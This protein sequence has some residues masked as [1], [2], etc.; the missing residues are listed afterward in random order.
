[1]P[2]VEPFHAPWFPAD[3]EIAAKLL[4][5]PGD[6][7]RGARVEP[8]ARRLLAAMRAP[9]GMGNVEK[10]LQEYSLS[11]REGLALMALAE[12]LLRVPDDSTLDLLIADKLAAGAFDRHAPASD[13]L[14]VQAAA[15]ALGLSTKIFATEETP[16]GLVAQA[17]RRLG[18]PALRGAARQAMKLMGGHFVLGQTIDEALARASADERWRYSFDMLGEGA[19]SVADAERY[20]AAYAAAIDAIGAKAGA[21][22]LPQ[23]PGVS[24]KL[25]ALHPRFEPLSRARVLRE[26]APRLLEL[27]RLARSHDLVFTIDAEEADRLELSLDV[28]DAV[29]ADSSLADWDG[30]GLAIQAYQKRAAAVIDHIEALAQAHDRRFMVRLVKGAYW[31][32]EIKRAQERGLADY[33]VFTRKAM[34]DLNYIACADRL[35]A[36]P[37][38]FPQ[39][40]THNAATVAT[41][42]ERAGDPAQYEFQR[43]H[44]MGEELFGALLEEQR[45][46]SCR[47]YAPVGPHRDLLAY[48]VRRLIEN[49]ANS[50]FIA[51]AAD[52]ATPESELLASPGAIIADASRA[53]HSRLPLPADLYRPLRANSKGVEFGDRDALAALLAER[54]AAPAILTA[55]PSSGRTGL[56]PHELRS[57]TDSSL[58]GSVVE[59]DVETAR[60]A[61]AIASRAFPAWEATPVEARAAILERAADLVEAHSGPLIALLQ[62]EGGKTLD[63]ALAEIREAADLSRY[64]AE[65]ARRL[66][67]EENLPGPTG[68][69]NRLRRRGRGNFVC[70]S[71][72]NFPLA[73][74]LGQVAAALAAGNS[75]I[76]KPAE[77]T[78]LV[79]REAVALLHEAGVPR[80]AL[81][82]MPGDGALGAA[83]VA[84][85]HVAGVVFTGSSEAAHSINRTLAASNGPIVPLIAETGGVNAMIVDST[86]LLE[87]VVDDVLASAFRSAG[88]RC[89]ALRLLCLQAD[90]AEDALAMLIGATKELRIGDPRDPSTHIGPVIDSAAQARLCDYLVQ[91]RA[92]G[93]VLYAGE[94]PQSGSFVAPHIVKLDRAGDLREEIFGPVLH[95]ATWRAEDEKDLSTLIDEISANGFG[96]TMGLHTRIEARMRMFAEATPAGNLYVNRNMI[97]AVVGSQPFGGSRM[98]GT[99][100][101][102][103]GPD[104]LRRF[105]REE[106]VTINTASF[107]GDARLLAMKE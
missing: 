107:G 12:S 5:Q 78:P 13:A 27:A 83:L 11:T 16:R 101:K 58:I 19:R 26:L 25:S 96:L 85:E 72:W 82:Y 32:T 103:G 64:Y 71:P 84:D 4:S 76:A 30:F 18:M 53:R 40:A 70:I 87:Q 73:I 92:Q 28:I 59:A 52:S 3:E 34:T 7:E 6:A 66:C 48:L 29:V 41:I 37:R 62:R 47:V 86:A 24:V 50:S 57:P 100:P 94:A 106:T 14:L 77:Q 15:F 54:D 102:A 63:D 88:Q 91:R 79:A 74:F 55:A 104:Y 61:M 95:I 89:S 38:I 44:G 68:E 22:T 10:L 56:A 93:R 1:M 2:P 9:K 39:F 75:A 81:H 20:F 69:D 80:D 98:S 99:G 60:A 45:N 97:A 51:R 8:L 31:D 35:L 21:R 49:G 42:V 17:A 23:R 33:P 43:L 65:Q 67:A 90:I 36:A 46:S 105:L